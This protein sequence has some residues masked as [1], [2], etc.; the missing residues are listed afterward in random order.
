MKQAI[1]YN[2]EYLD[3]VSEALQYANFTDEQIVD[4]IT[5]AEGSNWYDSTDQFERVTA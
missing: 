3:S 2:D 1:N 4:A 5:E